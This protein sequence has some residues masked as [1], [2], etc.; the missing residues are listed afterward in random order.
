M[1]RN[2]PHHLDTGMLLERRVLGWQGGSATR[3]EF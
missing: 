3:G 2:A 1:L